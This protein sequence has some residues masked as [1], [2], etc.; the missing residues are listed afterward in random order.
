MFIINNFRDPD[1]AFLASDYECTV[2][3]DG[4]PYLSVEHAFQ[5]AKTDDFLLREEIRRA[6]TARRA[7]QIGR[8]LSLK[9]GWDDVRE[10]VM[11]EL[12]RDKFASSDLAEKLLA[13][14][15]A[16]LIF[17]N[18][19]NDTYWGVCNGVGENRLGKILMTVRAETVKG[20]R[21]E[22]NIALT[23]YLKTNS[24]ARVPEGDEVWGEC[25]APSGNNDQWFSRMDAVCR[26][27]SLDEKILAKKGDILDRE[28]EKDDRPD[29]QPDVVADFVGPI[30]G[31]DLLKSKFQ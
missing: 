18:T 19:I 2:S 15:D 13:T 10:R 4:T 1:Y 24:W 3:L 31:L 17:E 25:W 8:R 5:A 22:L 11:F 30:F 29:V 12:V 6:L 21:Y 14:Q 16:E 7:K 20:N 26:Q 9:P 27:N 23:D 28:D